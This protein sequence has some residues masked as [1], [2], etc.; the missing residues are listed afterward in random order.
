[1]FC[2]DIISPFATII[3]PVYNSALK[4]EKTLECLIQQN[5]NNFEIIIVNDSSTDLTEIKARNIL[6]KSGLPFKIITHEKNLGVSAARNT[7]L[8]EAKGEYIWFVDS[9]D[10]ADRNFLKIMC[11]AAETKNAD[12]VFCGYKFYYER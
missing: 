9:D 12:L 7:G 4:I 1:M 3:V 6:A 2:N 10:L 5:Y 8:K 11:S